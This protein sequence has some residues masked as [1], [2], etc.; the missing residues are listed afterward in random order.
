[1]HFAEFTGNE[2]PQRLKNDKDNSK[3]KVYI[4]ILFFRCDNK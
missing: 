1:M 4:E 2:R 3:N